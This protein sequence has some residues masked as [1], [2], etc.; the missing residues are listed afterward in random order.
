MRHRAVALALIVEAAL[1]ANI[2]S[3]DAQAQVMPGR[4]GMYLCATPAIANAFFAD[5][6]QAAQLGVD[7]THAVEAQIASKYGCRFITSSRLWP[8]AFEME[9]FKIT[10]GKI[11]G[12]SAPQNYV[13]YMAH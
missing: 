10:D 2:A 7:V 8:I 3:S 13:N 1:M 9:Q 12:W 5:T 4:D 11:T 6:K